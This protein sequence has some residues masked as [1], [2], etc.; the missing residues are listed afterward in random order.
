MQICRSRKYEVAIA[1]EI[2]VMTSE[3][4]EAVWSKAKHANVHA[5]DKEFV[6]YKCPALKGLT[7]TVSQMYK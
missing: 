4:I 3:W 1:K 7:I 2:P 5:T 6:R